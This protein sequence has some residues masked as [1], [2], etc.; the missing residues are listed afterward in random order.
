MFHAAVRA[1]LSGMK[2]TGSTSTEE[3]VL[4]QDT[5]N[6][7]DCDGKYTDPAYPV[8]QDVIQI[9]ITSSLSWRSVKISTK[10]YLMLCEVEVFA[11][12]FSNCLK[13]YNESMLCGRNY[14]VF[15]Y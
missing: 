10:D 14:I 12:R 6:V 9:P 13:K 15:V 3:R 2:I 7:D 5:S 1:R 8:C 4:H 11:G